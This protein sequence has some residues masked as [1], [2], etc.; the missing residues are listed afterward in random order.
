MANVQLQS[1]TKR[2]DLPA[3]QEYYFQLIHKGLHLGFRR[4]PSTGA[5]TWVA[6]ILLENGRYDR[7]PLGAVTSD[8]DFREGQAAA[9]A[10]AAKALSSDAEVG[11]SQKQIAL[12]VYSYEWETKTHHGA[13]R[14]YKKYLLDKKG[15]RTL[16]NK[17]FK[18]R[19]VSDLVNAYIEAHGP[20]R[21]NGGW[22]EE[23][24]KRASN[25][26]HNREIGRVELRCLEASDISSL[27]RE[28][29]A[30]GMKPASVN[31]SVA[32]LRAALNWGYAEK[33]IASE[34]HKAAKR[35]KAGAHTARKKFP[36]TD[37]ADV[38]KNA[39]A[40]LQ[41][42]LGC[43]F[44]TGCRPVGARRLKVSDVDL[45]VGRVWFT[46]L[47]GDSGEAHRYYTTISGDAADFFAVQVIDKAP[48]DYVFTQENGRQW[49]ERNLPKV[50]G[51]YR[52][53]SG[54]EGW[55]T[56][57]LFRHAL[58]THMIKVGMPAAQAA[59]EYGTSIEYIAKNYYGRDDDLARKFA[60]SMVTA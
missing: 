47:K 34:P 52:T 5:E 59:E 3:R 12:T 14:E 48:E 18:I 42:I 17:K 4:S 20:L 37:C 50:F 22:V 21:A 43:L 46:S 41:P 23:S 56:L 30:G 51:T 44:Y 36:L 19:T 1:K 2:E 15:A 58:I 53:A 54:L 27:Q 40:A 60:V 24:D 9:I 7:A 32:I 29:R 11:T 16:A 33:L 35:E 6:R 49:S 26:V 31:R 25:V 10:A 38:V 57:Y 8:F 39:P 13:E 55:D 45:D 28:L